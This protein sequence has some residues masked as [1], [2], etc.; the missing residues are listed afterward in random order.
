MAVLH[1]EYWAEEL[2][3][4]RDG[5]RKRGGSANTDTPLARLS[6]LPCAISLS[7]SH[8]V[9][10]NTGWYI[11]EDIFH[12][13]VLFTGSRTVEDM[14]SQPLGPTAMPSFILH[15]FDFRIDHYHFLASYHHHIRICP[16]IYVRSS[17]T[18]HILCALPTSIPNK[19]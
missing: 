4:F 9:G 12:T 11:P 16:R 14:V 17:H 7:T 6:V 2:R 1:D 3:C 15:Y 13:F 10:V 5:G 18:R 19:D 8:G